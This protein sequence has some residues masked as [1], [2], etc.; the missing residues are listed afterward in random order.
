MREGLILHLHGTLYATEGMKTCFT[1]L[2]CTDIE[3]QATNMTQDK[4]NQEEGFFL[5]FSP[6]LKQPLVTA[7]HIFLLC[8]VLNS[9]KVNQIL[10]FLCL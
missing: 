7:T 10:E 2:L 6:H 4:D 8:H 1:F 5:C 9:S 3:T